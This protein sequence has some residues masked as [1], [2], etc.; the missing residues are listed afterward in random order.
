VINYLGEGGG[1]RSVAPSDGAAA[2]ICP[3]KMSRE[4]PS[5]R[6]K[7]T[8]MFRNEQTKYITNCLK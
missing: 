3:G 6:Q 1:G 8:E 2:A 7:P 5:G 4:T